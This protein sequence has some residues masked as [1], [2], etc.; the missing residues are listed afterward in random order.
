MTSFARPEPPLYKGAL[1]QLVKDIVGV[2][3][4]NAVV[5][6]YNPQK[7]SHTITPW[8]PQEVDQTQRGAQMPT[9]Q[10]FS[11]KESFSLSLELDATDELEIGH[12]VTL[13][14]GVGPRLAALKKLTWPSRGLHGDLVGS[15]S[16]QAGGA[17]CD[18]ERATVPIVLFVWSPGRI[19]PV[20]VSSFSVE[21]TLYSPILTPLHATVSL[22]LEVMT[23][24]NFK[25]QTDPPQKMAVAAYNHTRL[26][27]DDLAEKAASQTG[28]RVTGIPPTL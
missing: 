14:N 27:D 28:T 16:A 22:G 5:F 6:Q 8:N 15:A 10:P 7:L 17:S 13:V 18:V 20:R 26:L 19:L 21:E 2:V 4:Q 12:P 1:V 24:D 3:T 23:P 9:V 25:C 11:P